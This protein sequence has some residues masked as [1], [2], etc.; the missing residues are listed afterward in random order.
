MAQHTPVEIDPNELER[1]QEMWHAVTQ[2]SKY[3]IG[4][5]LVVLA[6]LALAFI[7]W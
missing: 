2:I 6:G 4:L 1:A 3:C 5:T 7:N